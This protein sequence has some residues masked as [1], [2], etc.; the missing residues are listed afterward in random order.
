MTGA[1]LPGRVAVPLFCSLGFLCSCG[2]FYVLIRRAGWSCRLWLEI[3]VILALG[4]T[5]L[6]CFLLVRA[7]VATK[8]HSSGYSLVMAGFLLAAWSLGVRKSGSG[9]CSCQVCALG[10]PLGAGPT[11]RCWRY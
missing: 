8:R 9:L 5:Q 2:V 1:E 6:V 10:L 11:L 4:N 3:L 7:A